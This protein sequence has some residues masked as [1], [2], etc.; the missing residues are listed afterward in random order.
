[1]VEAARSIGMPTFDSNNGVLMEADGG[2]SILDL[3]VRDGKRLSVFRTY[4]F[5][6][7]ARP[8]LT[9]LTHAMVTRLTLEDKRATGGDCL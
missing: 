5:P 1:M 8:N 3:R 7:M 6:F 4:V 2:A 9:V